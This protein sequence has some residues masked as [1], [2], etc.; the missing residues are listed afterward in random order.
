MRGDPSA[1]R[2][3]V[4][5]AN[6]NVS[7]PILTTT[8]RRA[9]RDG[10][11]LAGLLYLAWRFVV[12]G[13]QEGT[14]GGD[15]LAYWALDPQHP[16]ALPNGVFGAFLYPPPMVRVFAPAAILTWPQF[17]LLWMGVQIATVVWLGW[18]RS[19]LVLALPFVALELYFA[20]VN[21]LLGAA[22]VLGFRYP[23]AWA[24]VLLT[25][26]TP[27]VGLLWFAVRREWRQL[28]VALGVTAGIVAAS[29]VV[30]GRLWGEW[31]AALARDSG[32]TLGGPLASPLWLR[33]PVAAILVIWGARTDRP[34]T[35]LAAAT[36]ALPV[37]WLAALSVLAGLAALSRPELRPPSVP[38][39]K[40][41]RRPT[42]W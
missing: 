40:W 36:I 12:I 14:V 3:V 13:P 42:R 28:A 11:A 18:R 33:L 8:R 6:V 38:S 39:A 4:R 10:L 2:W 15:A 1:P 26:V 31:F 22:I 7:R 19:L 27:G 37:V 9:I 23:A 16:Y 5:W 35:V 17:W 21:L 34:W 41:S 29:L 30:D 20:N 25:K 24:F 32:A